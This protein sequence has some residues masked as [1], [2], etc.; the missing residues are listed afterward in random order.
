MKKHLT[1]SV[2][3]GATL[4]T[5][6]GSDPSDPSKANLMAAIEAGYAEND[7]F[8]HCF[9]RYNLPIEGNGMQLLMSGPKAKLDALAEL[10]LVTHEVE[11]PNT[12]FTQRQTQ[13]RYALTEEGA[14]YY[15]QDK[16]ICIGKP[17]LLDI[18]ELSEPFE[19]NG[20]T[21]ITG[22]YHWTLDV[23]EWAKSP[24]FYD[25][26]KLGPDRYYLKIDELIE[27]GQFDDYFRLTLGEEGW[28]L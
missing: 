5:G 26:D 16:G 6:C 15:E 19:E 17:R 20:R 8:P 18:S 25:N 12:E 2:L 28:S 1:M 10:G 23:P 11:G 14:R 27:E 22:T 3:F 4:L 13:H 24:D 9:F 7:N 21:Y